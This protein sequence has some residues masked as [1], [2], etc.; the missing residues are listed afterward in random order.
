[1][2]TS[3]QNLELSSGYLDGQMLIAM[4]TMNDPG[5]ARTVIYLCSHSNEGAMGIVIN[6]PAQDITFPTLLDQLGIESSKYLTSGDHNTIP[7]NIGGPVETTRGFVLH[8]PDYAND[9]STLTM[10]SDI[11]LT[12]TTGILEAIADGKGPN[13]AFLAL[14]YSGWDSGQLEAEIQANSWLHCMADHDIIFSR[15][16]KAKYNRSLEKIGVTPSRLVAY[17]GH[18]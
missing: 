6:K 18:A 17:S 7:V 16:I 4:P 8:S 15:N 12:A 13:L 1:M 3:G 2:T 14:G 9:A 11:S 5:F 10:D